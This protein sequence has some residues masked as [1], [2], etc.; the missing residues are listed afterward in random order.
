MASG[1]GSR[2]PFLESIQFPLSIP[3]FVGNITN[4]VP[5]IP[6]DPLFPKHREKRNKERSRETCE[7]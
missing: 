1:R 5:D 6:V 7:K 4:M 3:A 2:V